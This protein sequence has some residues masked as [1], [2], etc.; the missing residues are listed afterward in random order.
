MMNIRPDILTSSGTYFNFLTPESS[1]IRIEDIAIGLS[2]LCRFNGQTRR[3]GLRSP[4]YS[5]A[6][7]SLI[8][9]MIVPEE[10]ALAGLLHDAAEAYIGDITRPLKQLLPDFKAIEKRVEQRIFTHFGLPVEL[11]PCVKEADLVMLATEQRDLMAE[12]DDE[13][14]TITNVTPL[15]IKIEPMPSH[16]AAEAFYSRFLELM[17]DRGFGR[18]ENNEGDTVI[19]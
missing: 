7:H 16:A 9:S 15:A 4:F 11:D 8:V 10:H 14:A 5:V 3:V 18:H 2:N 13:W 19:V 6:Q 1:E 17:R 12:H